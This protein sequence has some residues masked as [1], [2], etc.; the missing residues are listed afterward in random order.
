MHSEIGFE[1]MGIYRVLGLEV[2]QWP[3][4]G[5]MIISASLLQHL[6]LQVFE[7]LLL[8]CLLTRQCRL[9]I[10]EIHGHSL[11]RRRKPL[12]AGDVIS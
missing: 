5:C 1:V 10:S 12:S 4:Q 2:R 8:Q 11:S 7:M 3:R 6:Q 9:V